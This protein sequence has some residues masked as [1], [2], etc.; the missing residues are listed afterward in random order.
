[1]SEPAVSAVFVHPT[2]LCESKDVGEDTRVWAFAHVMRGARVGRRCNIGDHA[3]IE[4]GARIGNGVTIKNH[5]MIWDG[6]TIEDEVFV[7]PGVIFT[8]DRY[9]RSRH[10]PAV[11]HHFRH[12]ENWLLPTTVRRGASL[13]AGARILCGIT[14]GAY[15]CIGLGAVVTRSVPGHG[16]AVGHPA[17][18]TGWVCL[19]GRTLN[20]ALT[21]PTCDRKFRVRDDQLV[22]AP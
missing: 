4:S 7:G 9:P 5:A 22:A 3:F 18:I 15:A 11:A 20:D 19:C 12:P 17:R 16:L 14:I 13:G 6:V 1:M 8:N 10:L 2:A 21:C